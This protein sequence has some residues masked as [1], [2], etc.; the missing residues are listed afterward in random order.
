MIKLDRRDFLKIIG[1]AGTS[2]A[3]GCSSTTPNDL[4]PYISPPEDLVPGEATWYASTCRECPAGCGLLAKNRDGR[5]IKVEGNPLHP[6]S[7][8][9]LCA[10]GQ[11]SLQG[12]YNPDRFPGPLMKKGK[13]K[14]VPVTW[15]QGEEV[16]VRTLDDLVRQ[17]RGERI[18]FISELMNGSL[19]ELTSLWLSTMN[20]HELLLYESFAY[21]PLRRAN[22]AVFQCDGVPHYRIDRA[23][24]LISLGAGFLETWISNLEFARQFAAFHSLQQKGKNPFVFVGPRLSL[25]ANNADQ[26]I[27]VPP[28]D[29]VLIGLGLLKVLLDEGA[30]CH[31]SSEQKAAL[32]TVLQNFAPEGI[33]QRTGVQ[34]AVIRNL[35][36]RFIRAER[37]LVLAE[38]QGLS[39]PQAF[40]AA[41]AANLLCLVKPGTQQTM[42][43]H[44]PS[45][46]G[47]AAPLARM[48]E[49]SERMKRG[50]VDLL[51]LG[52]VNPVFTL[53]FSSDFQQGLETVPLVVSFSSHLDETSSL[54]HLILPNHTFL[55]SWGDYSPREG[56]SGLMQPVMGPVFQT[57]QVGDVLL[58][59]GKKVRGADRFP[60]KDFYQYL[61]TSWVQKGK[62]L[63]PDLPSE[64]FWQK[65]MKRGGVWKETKPGGFASSFK[66]FSF[67]GLESIPNSDQ[68]L[69]LTIYPTIQ[70]FDG[71]AA[72]RPW[73][74]E[75]PDPLTQITW[76]GWL[77]IHPET[78][79]ALDI[80]KGEVL[81]VR[82][83][84]GSQEVPAYPIYTVPRGTL[85][86]PI[87]QGHWNY[88]RFADGHPANPLSLFPPQIDPHSG[89]MFRPA[90]RVSLQKLPKQISL[91]HVDGSFFQ[92]GRELMRVMEWKDYQRSLDVGQAPPIDLPL[93][94]GFDPEKDF[95]PPHLHREYRWGMVVDL[96]RC[97]GCSACVV[98]CYAENNVAVVGKEQVLKGREMSWIRIQR[99]F[100]EQEGRARWLPMLCQHCDYAPCESVCPVYAPVHNPEGLNTQV[101]NRCLGTRFCL[102]NDPYK[103]RRFNWFNYTRP[104]PLDWQLN[105]EVTVR[106]KG[107]MEK[108]SFCVQRIIGA[109]VRARDEGRKMRD[110]DFTTA[111]AQ[112]CPTDTLIFGNLLDPNSRVSRLI[113]DTRR[114]QVLGHLNTKPA[115]IY[116]KR[117]DQIYET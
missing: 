92:H 25:T 112:T 2:A 30:L 40:E 96:D 20:S 108:C 71:R 57:R 105:P 33:S 60:W 111:C 15:E 70:F 89:G 38:G 3:L 81:L 94:Q 95:Y 27:V 75:L 36:A 7:G 99:Y 72:N 34:A 37:P 69:D 101:Y 46:Y 32:A 76:D 53:P 62:D 55:E 85:A 28:G 98:A 43:F 45:V 16:L 63:E 66:A 21:E 31:F 58:S 64:E 74:Q 8:G 88:G 23:D 67:P 44:S 61:R 5:I 4:I 50:D 17:G 39:G 103:V 9:K 83:P 56:V 52:Q 104:K 91:A 65:A 110:G 102:Q 19:R 48:K 115:V 51:L 107:V 116:L 106:Q 117:V 100:E 14:L 18:V 59:S 12:L 73:I 29:E 113:Q 87:G 84:Y 80:K 1:L 13:G 54:A 109:K 26:W 49:L 78:A 90:I 6:V 47:Q 79:R 42:N 93:P 97:I 82:S 11:A 114:Y 77:E 24:F 41:V 35:A 68:K 10:R 86:M 22:Q